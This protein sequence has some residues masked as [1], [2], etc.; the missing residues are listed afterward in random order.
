MK[1]IC[2]LIGWA[3]LLHSASAQSESAQ[4]LKVSYESARTDG[5]LKVHEAY[6]AELKEGQRARLQAQDL[7]GANAIEAE[8]QQV[9]ARIES[10]KKGTIPPVPG[11]LPKSPPAEAAADSTEVP[12][13]ISA[14]RRVFLDRLRRGLTVLDGSFL[15]KATVAQKDLMA[16]ADLNGANAFE[17]LK[18]SLKTELDGLRDAAQV[19][20]AAAPAAD[21][22]ESRL[23][24]EKFRKYWVEVLG[25]WKFTD[26]SLVGTGDSRIDFT[27]KVR[28]PFV[29]SYDFL[30]KEGMRPRVSLG[31]LTIANE[32]YKNQLMLMPQET[33]E[34][35]V[36]YEVGRK[37]SVRFVANRK[38]VEVYLNGNLL[39]R[40]E[41]GFDD[42]LESI[43]FSGGDGYSPG[44]TEFS[45]I[46]L[47]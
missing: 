9:R 31:S 32:G 12:P 40:R 11:L 13:V 6:E 33:G 5:F 20:P 16:R 1:P 21:N 25:D 46:R 4:Q 41:S 38:F 8:L 27:R 18:T 44:I 3:I 36:P 15:A 24:D 42:A 35:A 28:A 7:P 14:S 45:N 10:L 29:L 37:Y 39:A 47:E 43:G 30:V 26:G 34:P 23:L 19:V 2:I 22:S 17:E